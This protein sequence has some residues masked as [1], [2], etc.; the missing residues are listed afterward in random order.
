MFYHDCPFGYVKHQET[1]NWVECIVLT[2]DFAAE[3]GQMMTNQRMGPKTKIHPC[4]PESVSTDE[5][6]VESGRLI[7]ILKKTKTSRK[8]IHYIF[9]FVKPDFRR[10]NV[11]GNGTKTEE[12]PERRHGSSRIL[13]ASLLRK[14]IKPIVWAPHSPPASASH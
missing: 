14:A 3:V 10:L 1:A 4:F 5:P 9:A 11:S 7:F 2:A 12:E 8:K 6:A 13:E